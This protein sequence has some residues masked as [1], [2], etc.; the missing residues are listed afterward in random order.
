MLLINSFVFVTIIWNS[1]FGITLQILIEK[2]LVSYKW[3]SW[4]FPNAMCKLTKKGGD[5]F[6]E[7]Y[8]TTNQRKHMV[9][10]LALA[11][12]IAEDGLVGHQWEERPE[13]LWLFYAPV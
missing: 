13:V 3:N 4:L 7:L 10:L 11:A 6:K 2:N 1:I 8:T 9:G 5:T 12:Y